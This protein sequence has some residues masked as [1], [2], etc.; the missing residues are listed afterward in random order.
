[1]RQELSSPSSRIE[2]TIGELVETIAQI[3]LEAGKTEAE[4]Y[5]LA[6]IAVDNILRKNGIKI[7]TS[8]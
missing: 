5:A 3:A 8:R 7:K 1:M 4:G 6:T 2:T